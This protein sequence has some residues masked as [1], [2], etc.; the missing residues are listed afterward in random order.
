MEPAASEPDQ[1]EIPA[2]SPVEVAAQATADNPQPEQ[3]GPPEGQEE[4]EEQARQPGTVEE[5]GPLDIEAP[6]LGAGEG[7]FAVGTA[8]LVADASWASR[9][10][11]D[12]QPG[13]LA[14]PWPDDREVHDAPASAGGVP[15]SGHWPPAADCR[16]PCSG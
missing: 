15:D 16:Q 8:A 1:A 10:I 9:P 5:L 12:Q 4:D 13:H 3:L 6:A 7:G 14:A 2:L 11:R